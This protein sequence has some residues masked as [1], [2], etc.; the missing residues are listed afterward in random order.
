MYK[1]DSTKQLP[2][3]AQAVSFSASTSG[4]KI[5]IV[6]ICADGI[7]STICGSGKNTAGQT[8]RRSTG[9]Q[10]AEF[11]KVTS[12]ELCSKCIKSGYA[13]EVSA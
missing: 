7:V 11:D 4:K 12:N 1:I 13:S 10:T 9:Y 2:L 8:W 5:H 3:L 6:E